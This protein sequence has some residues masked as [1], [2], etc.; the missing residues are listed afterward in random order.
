MLPQKA[1]NLLINLE[2][3][4]GKG[5]AVGQVGPGLKERAQGG[6]E[7]G[8]KTKMGL[9]KSKGVPTG[10]TWLEEFAV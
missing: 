2:I 9:K 1:S 7:V 4:L 6:C 3:N 5:P 8:S 10:Q